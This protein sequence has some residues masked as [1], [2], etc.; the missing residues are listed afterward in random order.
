[1]RGAFGLQPVD[2]E[3]NALASITTGQ[4]GSATNAVGDLV[5]QFSKDRACKSTQSTAIA[6]KAGLQGARDA[7]GESGAVA[8]IDR[9]A[10]REVFEV[11]TCLP[12]SLGKTRPWRHGSYR[13]P[14]T[15][16]TR[17]GSPPSPVKAFNG[18][19]MALISAAFG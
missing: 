4:A 17:L 5:A 1:M 15:P 19:Y 14:S 8:S 11:V 7:P 18:S 2:P 13:W 12:R 16:R 3:V 9:R 6:Q 10:A